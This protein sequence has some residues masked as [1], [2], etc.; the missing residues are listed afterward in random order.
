MKA[1]GGEQRYANN[2]ATSSGSISRLMAARASMTFSITSA[3]PMP[4]LAA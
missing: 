3:S 2:S 1:A 4:W